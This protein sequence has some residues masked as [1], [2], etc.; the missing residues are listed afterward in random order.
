MCTLYV[1]KF[2]PVCPIYQCWQLLHFIWY[3]PLLLY[4]SVS[5]FLGWRWFCIVFFVLYAIRMFVFLNSLVMA[6]VSLLMYVNV[7]HFCFCIVLGVM[8]VF[9]FVLVYKHVCGGYLLLCDIVFISCNLLCLFSFEIGCVF[10]L[11]IRYLIAESLCSVGWHKSLCMIRSVVVGF[12]Y[13]LK[14]NVL[15]VCFQR[16]YLSNLVTDLFFHGVLDVGMY[17]IE[18]I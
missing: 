16:L 14:V 8:F 1:L 2:L 12:L 7:A 15:C 18:L 11:L 10:I 3:I 4:L 17:G 9:C 6:L 13:I 5:C